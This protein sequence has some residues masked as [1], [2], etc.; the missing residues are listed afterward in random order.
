MGGDVHDPQRRGD[1]HHGIVFGAG[2]VR[3]DLRVARVAEAGPGPSPPC[4]AAR[5]R[6]H[7]PAR[8]ERDAARTASTATRPLRRPPRRP[9]PA[10]GP[11]VCPRCRGCPARPAPRQG[12]SRSAATPPAPR[13]GGPQRCRA[14]DDRRTFLVHLRVRQGFQDD[15][16]ADT[17]G[18]AHGDGDD[19]LPHAAP[20]PSANAPY[21]HYD[22]SDPNPPALVTTRAP[23]AR[24]R[25][26]AGGASPPPPGP[27][28]AAPPR[29]GGRRSPPRCRRPSRPGARF[30]SGR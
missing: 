19:R 16:R 29:P 7:R 21:A 12:S 23:S 30:R 20:S 13:T 18:V 26:R 9:A 2:Q 25:T 27:R 4:S 8:Q 10:P 1:Q 14:A 6:W 15:L 3:Q 28:S 24:P 5:S 11:S 22:P 17:R